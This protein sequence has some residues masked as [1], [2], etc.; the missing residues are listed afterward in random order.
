[1]LIARPPRTHRPDLR[2]SPPGGDQIAPVR[3]PGCLIESPGKIFESE[4]PRPVI[5]KEELEND[6]GRAMVNREAGSV[7]RP[8]GQVF[9]EGTV[10]GLTDA[11][12][13]ER[14]AVRNDPAAFE[15]LLISAARNLRSV[16]DSPSR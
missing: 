4:M 1:M 12:L 3:D 8:L 2:E 10:A 6:G 15:A 11:Q 16:G 5:I 9:R 7:L 14:Y 13:L